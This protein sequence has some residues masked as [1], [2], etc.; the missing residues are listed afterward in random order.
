MT[1]QQKSRAERAGK[2]MGFAIAEMANL[3]YQENTKQ[4]F[5]RGLKFAIDKEIQNLKDK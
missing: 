5:Y 2:Q 3:M 1:R 4:N